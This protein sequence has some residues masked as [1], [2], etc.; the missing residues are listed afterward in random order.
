MSLVSLSR[1]SRSSRLAFVLVTLILITLTGRVARAEELSLSRALRLARQRAPEMKAARAT[2]AGADAAVSQARTPYLPSLTA[3]GRG[4]EIA[5]GESAGIIPP[6]QTPVHIVTYTTAGT[7]AASLRWTLIDFGRTSR[8]VRAAESG[9]DASASAASDIEAR[10]VET[11]ANAYLDV[12]YGEKT[13]DIQRAIVEEREKSISIV[14]ALVKQ[15]L[16]PAVEDLRAQSRLESARRDAEISDAAF[17]EARAGLLAFLGLDPKSSL[18]LVPPKLSRPRADVESVLRDA[19]HKKPAVVAAQKSAEAED[20]KVDAARARYFP[21]VGL[22]GDAS[23]RIAN[24]DIFNGWIPTRSATGALVL[25]VPI[26]DPT[27]SANLEAAKAQSEKADAAYEQ[28][29]RDART[30]AS[31]ALVALTTSDRVTEH[32]RKAA[33]SS[34]AVLAVIRARYAQG[35]SSTLDLI[36]AETTDAEARLATVRAERSADGAVIR[37]LA[38]IGKTSR[39]VE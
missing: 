20:A 6:R 25:T 24:I 28:A 8:G 33:E 27:N 21:T 34:A 11:V 38:A 9:R 1:S 4:E 17:V 19:D 32:A 26:F 36:D 3:T 23:Y 37:L 12:A 15:G 31:Q 5:F 16:A 22:A 14:K 39:L 18:S 29:R 2:V 13:R 7:L 30:T 35:L 10:L